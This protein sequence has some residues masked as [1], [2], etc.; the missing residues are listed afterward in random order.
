MKDLDLVGG[1]D[2]H[3]KDIN[4]LK[5]FSS[6]LSTFEPYIR[7]F[8]KE[9]PGTYVYDARELMDS[10]GA[11]AWKMTADEFIDETQKVIGEKGGRVIY[12]E[13]PDGAQFSI[14]YNYGPQQGWQLWP[15]ELYRAKK[16]GTHA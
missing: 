1:H 14:R 16:E 6:M 12:V 3:P 5:R 11:G 2:N 4:E 7:E 15:D 8:Y 9:H 13:A 10:L